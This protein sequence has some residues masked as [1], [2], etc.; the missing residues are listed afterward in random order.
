MEYTI[1]NDFLRVTVSTKGAEVTSV[2]HKWDGVE[3]MWQAD[4][5]VWDY[6]APILFP[7]AGR[8]KENKIFAKGR[9]FENCPQHG[10]AR[11][12]AHKVVF[13]SENTLVMELTESAE[14]LQLWPYRFRL[15]STFTLEADTLLHCLTVE[16]RD[17]EEMPFGIGFHPG[18]RLPFDAEHQMSDYELRFDAPESPVCLET[19]GG[20]VSG[21]VYCLG[22][23]I[24]SITLD[25]HL[26]ANDSH[27]MTGL[28]SKTLGLYEK[29]TG[30][31]VVCH[32]EPFPHVLI[33]SKPGMPQFVCIEPWNSLP[34]PLDGT[35]D[36]N[37]K[38]AAA[39]LAPGE[40]WST[41]MKTV[42]KR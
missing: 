40:S 21:K 11:Q 5:A 8:V 23:N 18:F 27:L 35:L 36:W 3:H 17:E 34:S 2:V 9:L 22:E 33:W 6:H 7:Y 25:E 39:I 1:E 32:I 15:V 28:Q 37:A 26:F 41:T 16:N 14:T 29:E 13:C 38:P 12:L 31:A 20:L 24:R 30:R 42:F 4:P 10:F 19:P